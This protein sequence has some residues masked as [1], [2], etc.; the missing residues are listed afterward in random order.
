MGVLI[1][2]LLSVG[3]SGATSSS[4]A[5]QERWSQFRGSPELTGISHS[6]LPE[7][8]ELLW[9]YEG[10]DS[11]DSSAAIVDGVVYV[12]TF[13]GD[14]LALS[15]QDGSLRWK[16]SVGE[17][18]LGESSPAVSNGVVYVGDL[19][20]VVHA[21]DTVSGEAVW[22]FQTLG[23]IKSSPVIIKEKLLIGSYDEHV[24]CLSAKS[25]ELLWKLRSNGFIHGTPATSKGLTYVTGCDSMLRAV[26]IS[27]WQGDVSDRL[28]LL[29]CR[30]PRLS[31][32]ASPI[33][34]TFDNQVLAVD[35]AKLNIAWRYEH[36][37]RHFPFYSSA[38]V[39]DGR[40]VLG[41]RDKMVHCLDARSG[42]S[43]VDFPHRCS[44]RF[45]T[46]RDGWPGLHRIE[47]RTLIRIRPRDRRETLGVRRRRALFGFPCSSRGPFGDRLPG[48]DPL[49]LG[50]GT[51]NTN[52]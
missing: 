8:L 4:Q 52:E 1:S 44:G 28:R 30:I 32:V 16:Y 37:V 51:E 41:G 12:G 14:L 10:D 25:G 15:L 2:V 46:R 33:Y 3:V 42:G 40:V 43:A 5:T 26:R 48:R 19:A 20:G 11:I 38:A 9:T 18:G 7:A 24:Y 21:V 27:R 31:L 50:L 6:K 49:L 47:R 13:S 23:E 17:E 22:T 36:P 35:L 39:V 29:Y 45:F 34:G